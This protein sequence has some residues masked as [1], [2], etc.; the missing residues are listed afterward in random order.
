MIIKIVSKIPIDR[1]NGR[2][3]RHENSWSYCSGSLLSFSGDFIFFTV[4]LLQKNRLERGVSLTVLD[5]RV[6]SP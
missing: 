4:R 5:Y 2:L 6:S 3:V 1:T